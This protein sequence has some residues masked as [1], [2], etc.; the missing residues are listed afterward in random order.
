MS[1]SPK[2]VVIG[3]GLGGL[4]SAAY[5][6][7]DGFDVT[8]IEKSPYPGGRCSHRDRDGYIVTTGAM[9]VPMGPSSAIRQAFDALG[10][11]MDMID[12]TGRMRYR[13]PHGDY[14]LPPGGG[15]LAGMVEFAMQDPDAARVLLGHIKTALTD[16]LPLETIT[17]REWFDQY[18]DNEGVKQLFDGYCSALMGVRTHELSAYDFFLFL[19]HSSKG[20]RFG[21]ARKGNLSL[22][23][24]LVAGIERKGGQ[25]R[26]HVGCKAIMA[27]GNRIKGVRVKNEAG[28]DEFIEA[29]IVISNLGPDATVE[30]CGGEQKF[31]RSYVEKLHQ[32]ATPV[33]IYHVCFVMDRP[34]VP[35]FD[36]CMVFSNNRN[37]IYLEIPSLISPG[38]YSPEGKY[39]HTAYGA[40]ENFED[41]NLE[42]ELKRTID[43][44]E[45]NFPGFKNEA[46]ILVKAKF[47]GKYPAGRRAV[48]RS[49]PVN[50]P[51]RG[52]YMVGDGNAERGKIGTESAASSGRLAAEQI[53]QRYGTARL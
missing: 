49:M 30:L 35:D 21:L 2:V 41:A 12:V 39:V 28:E 42:E 36:G 44:L 40:P 8:L 27:E 26:C 15:G 4:C 7:A 18:T 5:L 31:E 11:E 47:S 53:K 48:G 20:T 1:S 17:L 6:V 51:I 50:T 19:K 9:M 25:V 10:L 22:V 13:M 52:L 23:S 43:E 45:L 3:A 16:W 29:D 24:D 33:P 14:D 34:L 46:E 38:E 37:L 32:D